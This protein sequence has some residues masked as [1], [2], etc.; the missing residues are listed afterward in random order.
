ME[1]WNIRGRASAGNQVKI[2]FNSPLA[3]PVPTRASDAVAA[4]S[5]VTDTDEPDRLVNAGRFIGAV[6]YPVRAFVDRYK[7]ESCIKR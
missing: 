2:K 4:V 1:V 7:M 5:G 3:V 6:I